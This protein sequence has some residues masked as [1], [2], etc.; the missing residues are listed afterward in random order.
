MIT[1][2]F[3]L[4]TS[5]CLFF[6]SVHAE[7]VLTANC[8]Q[9]QGCRF[10]I[11]EVT[12]EES[13][14]IF[15]EN[16]SGSSG[17]NDIL[18]FGTTKG[19]KE[20]RYWERSKTRSQI[21]RDWGGDGYTTIYPFDPNIQ[22]LSGR[23][24]AQYGAVTGSDCFVD[25]LSIL[26]R[27]QGMAG[28]GDI[29][30]KKPFSPYQLFPSADMKWSKAGYAKYI[31]IL[32]FGQGSGSPMK[33]KYTI[34]IINGERIE[35]VYDLVIKIPVKGTCTGRIP[36]TFTCLQPD[37]GQ[38]NHEGVIDPFEQGSKARVD[39]ITDEPFTDVPVLEDP[40]KPDVERIQDPPKPEVP[41][42]EDKS[43]THVP[44]ITDPPKP[45]V[46]R[47]ENAPKA[48]VDRIAD[49]PQ[50]KVEALRDPAPPGVERLK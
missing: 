17:E 18:V 44:R 40:P 35:T 26:K 8:S 43:Q 38:R 21:D 48:K 16:N 45:K 22:P 47:L 28:A 33:M 4:T 49:P 12:V 20:I 9:G 1:M 36:V 46:P 10:T 14:V 25:I 24:Q 13:D 11:S 23:W 30:F 15:H 34:R 3:I 6:F 32:D 2:R 7:K 31:G 19:G 5:L 37:P 39:P 27:A 50:P 29:Q 41:R 42:I